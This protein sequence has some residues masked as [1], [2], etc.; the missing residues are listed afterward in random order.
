[1]DLLKEIT[2]LSHEF[3]TPEYLKGGGGNTSA[4]N[5]ETLWIK[6]SG[7]SLLDM[8]PELFV[9]LDRARLGVLYEGQPPADPTER[10]AWVKATMLAA[11]REGSK[12]RPS[13][14]APLHNLMAGAYV[15]HT[16]PALVN[17]MTS[18]KTGPKACGRLF[19]DALWVDYGDPGFTVCIKLLEAVRKYRKDHHRE[20][21]AIFLGN[22]GVFVGDDNAD[23]VRAAYQVMMEK[24]KA[25]Y[26]K[27][28]VAM[29]LKVGP[30]PAAAE[31]ESIRARVAQVLGAE[32]AQAVAGSGSFAI[33]QGPVSPDQ[34]VYMRSYP[35]MGE[36]TEAALRAF[37]NTHRHSPRVVVTANGVFGLG[38]SEKNA[39]LALEL[40]LDA[41][42]VRQ[43]ADAFG[44]IRYMTPSESGFIDNWEVE[45]YRRKMM[46]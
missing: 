2:Q 43:L 23:A 46:K 19:P 20:P 1:M 40:A 22:H 34:I 7:T 24:L 8:K 44:G 38:S 4:K 30:A 45:A 14:E 42:L 6:P 41:A 32:H 25:E 10:E 35:L 12:G 18:G 5:A 31:G 11:V 36:P 26:R 9:A 27:A 33:A 3:G 13:V 21:P 37:E 15:V 17:G 39:G 28:R 16:H 29:E